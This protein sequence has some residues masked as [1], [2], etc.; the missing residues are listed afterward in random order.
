M[1]KLVLILAATVATGI[2]FININNSIVDAP[3]WGRDIPASLVT[4]REYFRVAN[5]GTFFRFASPLSQILALVALIVCW[6]SG[7]RLRIYCL[8]ALASAIGGEMLTFAYFF[9]RNEIMF[10]APLGPDTDA[11][12]ATWKEWS[13]MNWVRSG[14]IAAQVI[15][16]YLALML[17]AKQ[18]A[19]PPYTR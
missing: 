3:N 1:R 19:K 8:L 10:I 18:G 6:R 14:I 11:L 2:L 5:P 12:K 7:G 17:V 16:D 13:T 4:A 15:F 9:P